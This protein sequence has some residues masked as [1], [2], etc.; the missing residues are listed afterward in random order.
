MPITSTGIG[1]GLDVESLVA[2]L[3]LAEVQPQETR[4]NTTEAAYQAEISSFGAIKSALS[5][6]QAS[7]QALNTT[8]T[9]QTMSTSVSDYN[10][11]SASASS[12]AFPGSYDL[13]VGNLATSHS[14]ASVADY[15]ATSSVVGTGVLTLA[16][17][18]TSYDQETDVY[19]SFTPKTGTSAVQITIDSSNNT[20]AGIRDAINASEAEATA[21][22]VFDGSNYRL[23]LSA[24]ESGAANTL[25]I[26]ADDADGIDT[27]ST[28]LSALS[29][30]SS[31]TNLTQTVAGADATLTV[32]GLSIS[33]GSNVVSGAIEGLD[34]TLKETFATPE[35]VSIS[36]NTGTIKSAVQGFVDAYNDVIEVFNVQT[37]YDSETGRGSTLTGDAT[38]RTLLS[39]I[40]NEL[41]R[42]VINPASDYSYAAEIGLTSSTLDGKL[43]ID[44]SK[45]TAALSADPLGVATVFSN[46]ARPTSS[47]VLFSS[48]TNSTSEGE[49][50][51]S[52]TPAISG[53]LLGAALAQNLN[54]SG[55]GNQ[56]A[57]F[58]ITVDGETASVTIDSDF[59][60]DSAAALGLQSAINAALTTKSVT[61]SLSGSNA[62]QLLISSTSSGSDSAVSVANLDSDASDLG[63]NSVSTTTGSDAVGTIG[64]FAATVSGTELTGVTGTPVAGLKI[65]VLGGASSQLGSV[66]YSKGIASKL[67]SLLTGLLATNG[68]IDAKLT[69]LTASVEDIAD[70][71][72][73][74]GQRAENLES[75]YR[76]QFN[77]LETLISS[78][79][80]TSSF[81]TQALSTFVAPLS[82][83]KK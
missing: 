31:A 9:Y 13:T 67:D 19:T 44:D 33:S 83:K 35:T 76:N 32:N 41:N 7:A 66:F 59:A 72:S 1:S 39:S 38:V 21:S 60:D 43:S 51:V 61:V 34:L 3:V 28:G 74:L 81:L 40:R 78:I 23:V 12:S 26:T 16:I 27:N 6:L 57:T 42:E 30:S 80:E 82:F 55:N 63:L 2:Q 53:S 58:D 73:A 5:N 47:N 69:G 45:L 70:A 50:A 48:A 54:F 8:S 46:F 15:S 71:R 79:N 11:L 4:L 29:F 22:I 17:G 20:L 68:L 14:L 65:K 52:F 24:N 49:Y 77:G 37:S 25:S 10:K 75:I 56:S 62:D 36:K 64:G 18:T